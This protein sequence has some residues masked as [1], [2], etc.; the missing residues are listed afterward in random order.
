MDTVGALSVIEGVPEIDGTDGS[1]RLIVLSDMLMVGTDNGV[2]V[3]PGI[4]LEKLVVKTFVKSLFNV[5]P[6]TTELGV[7]RLGT[8]RL[9]ETEGNDKLT[10][11]VP[12]RGG[13]AVTEGSDK[14]T[15]GVP[16]NRGEVVTEGTPGNE[17]VGRTS[18]GIDKLPET[19]TP[20]RLD[21][22]DRPE[23]IPVLMSEETPGS[24]DGTDVASG[25][26]LDTL[27]VPV[28]YTVT[29][30]GGGIQVTVTEPSQTDHRLSA[31]S[32]TQWE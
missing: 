20:S 31:S 29:V 7:V 15:D 27:K 28:V 32:N 9:A 17:V 3:S 24:I 5:T 18:E 2:V 26:R 1:D 8:V 4:M 16:D 10:D 23:T 11:G 22:V 14:L 19:E 30:N 6:G 13:A 21:K 12:D 25:I